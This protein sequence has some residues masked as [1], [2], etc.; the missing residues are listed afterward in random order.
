[1]K[2]NEALI[3]DTQ[4]SW[5]TKVVKTM[6]ETMRIAQ[7]CILPPSG[8]NFAEGASQYPDL[9][10][11]T[12]GDPDLATPS[13]ILEPAF[14]DARQGHTK[15]TA[16]KGDPALREEICRYYQR[17]YGLDIALEEVFVTTAG[18]IGMTEA[19]L[20]VIDPGDEV[21][22]PDPY[23]MIYPDQIR[24]AGGVPVPLPTCW[25]EGFA[26]NPQR[27]E[28]LITPKTR[29]ILL[30]TPNN[31]TGAV[32]TKEN[33]EQVA[34]ICIR[35]DLVAICDDIYTGFVYGGSQF[36]PMI[37]IEGMRHR[38]ICVNSFSKNFVMTGM[39]VGNLV[40]P[41]H[42]IEAVDYLN[43]FLMYTAPSISQRAAIYALRDAEQIT[44]AIAAEFGRRLEYAAE[45]I[46]RIP[47]MS[48]HKPQGSIYLFP[49]I[50]E[51]G[52][53]SRQAAA[54]LLEKA[55]V[56]TMP[57]DEFGACGEGYL[58]IACTQAIP[59]LEQAFDRIEQAGLFQKG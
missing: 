16:T 51:S 43:G 48:V 50:R 39:R 36:V 45:R 35:H 6:Q 34:E 11:L 10:N 47:G 24:M 23:F 2:S 32:Y 29:A 31:P 30:N 19:L 8:P 33:L 18:C 14:E 28:S 9:I 42:V 25:E 58:R 56:L 53:S 38:T 4:F 17:A 41:P 21:I 49:S 5:N 37:T 52:L 1:M 22:V 44:P 40:A 7:R 27:L 55:H 54:L 57:G 59:V 13:Q 3:A 15:Y 20:A 46:G 26:L 12:I